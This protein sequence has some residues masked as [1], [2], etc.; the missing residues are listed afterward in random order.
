[1]ALRVTCARDGQVTY[2]GDVT[3]GE[4]G[5]VTLNLPDDGSTCSL[6]DPYG[7]GGLL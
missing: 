4:A 1:M 7:N 6:V 2:E 5:A 3:V